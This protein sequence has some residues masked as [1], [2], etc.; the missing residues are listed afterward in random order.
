M[1]SPGDGGDLPSAVPPALRH[2]DVQYVADGVGALLHRCYSVVVDG[3]DRGPEVVMAELSRDP[4]CAV[5]DAAV[6]QRSRGE[7]GPMRLGDEFLIR[8]PAPWDG[9]VR[10]IDVTPYSFRF[11]TLADHLEAGQIEFRCATRPD[12]ALT[13]E[14]ESWARPGD[15]LAH[16]LYNWLP[17]AKEIQ[18]TVWA[19]T[20]AAVAELV[21]GTVRGGV[22]VITRVV[23]GPTLDA[24]PV[25]V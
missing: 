15:A 25:G 9:P 3:A 10:V 5:P 4:N 2:D 23:D 7:G 18:L 1:E 8:M 21:G 16:V 14:I 13:F 19:R 20:C 11:A 22:S 24:L 12:G 6:F 17:L